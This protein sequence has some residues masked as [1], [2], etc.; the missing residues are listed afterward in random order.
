MN[1]EE[2]RHCGYRDWMAWP[3]ALGWEINTPQL[4]KAWFDIPILNGRYI[5]NVVYGPALTRMVK[6]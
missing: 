6:R 5:M 2:S 1:F 4:D 3:P